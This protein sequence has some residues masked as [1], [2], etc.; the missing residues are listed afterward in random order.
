MIPASVAAPIVERFYQVI[1]PD[2]TTVLCTSTITGSCDAYAADLRWL[3]QDFSLSSM[4]TLTP[5]GFTAYT[6]LSP[7]RSTG[8]AS[9]TNYLRLRYYFYES[10]DLGWY[11]FTGGVG[12]FTAYY[13]SGADRDSFNRPDHVVATPFPCC[14]PILGEYYI[15]ETFNLPFRVAGMFEV[16]IDVLCAPDHS[17][18]DPLSYHDSSYFIQSSQFISSFPIPDS[19]IQIVP[20]TAIPESSTWWLTT[21]AILGGG[22]RK[23]ISNRAR[24]IR[25][26]PRRFSVWA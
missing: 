4:F 5:D 22:G 24:Q 19:A 10:I 12:S 20:A 25:T 16:D 7:L 1:A 9:E 13:Q 15:T 14:E 17:N 2:Q 26:R 23:W 6:D 21:A 18:C 11:Q 3:A 8:N